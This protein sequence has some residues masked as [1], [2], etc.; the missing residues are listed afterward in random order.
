MVATD[1]DLKFPT[2]E[3]KAKGIVRYFAYPE[4]QSV[5]IHCATEFGIDAAATK[6][7]SHET[8][9]GL[10]NKMHC[11]ERPVPIHDNSMKK[12]KVVAKEFDT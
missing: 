6:P 4:P 2:E 11:G 8:F 3:D 9:E 5:C 10:I 7:I 1:R 12:L